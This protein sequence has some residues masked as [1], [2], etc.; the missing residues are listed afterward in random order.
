[1]PPDNP[2]QRI[3]LDDG[4][5]SVVLNEDIFAFTALRHGEAWR[6]LCGD[7]LILAMFYEIQRLRDQLE[8]QRT[9][10]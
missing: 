1:M 6:N 4:K 5:Y 2:I 8:D 9:D 3:D 7:N 10:A